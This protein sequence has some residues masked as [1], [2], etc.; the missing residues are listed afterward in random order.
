MSAIHGGSKM[1][2]FG[3]LKMEEQKHEH[4]SYREQKHIK[5]REEANL[6]HQ[7]YPS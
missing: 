3:K 5:H 2:L 6:I 7:G 1:E 4:T